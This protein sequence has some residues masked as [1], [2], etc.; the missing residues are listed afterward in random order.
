[1]N[2]RFTVTRFPLAARKMKTEKKYFPALTCY[3]VRVSE[4][5][6][7]K[8]SRATHFLLASAAQSIYNP[9]SPRIDF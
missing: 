5:S 6:N 4:I 8:N 1:M 3:E 7:K 9:I 2:P